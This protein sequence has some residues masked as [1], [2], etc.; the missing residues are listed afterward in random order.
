MRSGSSRT[1]FRESRAM[2][3]G[4]FSI[5]WI[6]ASGASA[7]PRVA[8]ETSTSTLGHMVDSLE[9]RARALPRGPGDRLSF[10]AA[11]DCGPWLVNG[12]ART[13]ALS[14]SSLRVEERVVSARFRS[15]VASFNRG[16]QQK[17]S[18]RRGAYLAGCGASSR[19]TGMPCN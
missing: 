11:V 18:L 14:V 7:Q 5:R 17:R 12:L 4:R 1:S 16:R 6:S 9:R 2:A 3:R 13:Q 15:S 10:A 19:S 8:F